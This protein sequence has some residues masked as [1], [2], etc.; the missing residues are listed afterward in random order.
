MPIVSVALR[1]NTDHEKVN[2]A[3][4]ND[5]CV[6]HCARMENRGVNVYHPDIKCRPGADY[7]FWRRHVL[8]PLNA[9]TGYVALEQL[10]G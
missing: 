5:Y 9:W 7:N 6:S 4:A 8:F 1:I 2:L 10:I 3:T